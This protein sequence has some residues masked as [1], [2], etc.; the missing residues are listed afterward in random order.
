MTFTEAYKK[1]NDHFVEWGAKGIALVGETRDA[2]VF[3]SHVVENAAYSGE[4]VIVDKVTGQTR[5]LNMGYQEDRS[6]GY[7]AE[8]IDSQTLKMMLRN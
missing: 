1:V 2:W 4:S 3:K 6:I 5:F 7:N 8:V